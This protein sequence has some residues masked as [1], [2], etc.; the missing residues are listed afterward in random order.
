MKRDSRLF[1]EQLS[2]Y[3][4]SF[5]WCSNK[6]VLDAGS[7]DGYGAHLVSS[8][9]KKITLVDI[10]EKMLSNAKKYHRWLCPAEFIINDF[11]K[12]FPKGKWDTILAFEII[13]HLK[14]SDFF[15]NNIKKHL[16]YMGYFIFSVPHMMKNPAHKVLFDEEKIKKLINKYFMIIEFYIQDL[17]NHRSYF[18]IAQNI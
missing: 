4:Y 16:N 13:E 2:R 8:L 17:T 10:S 14:D 11:E 18:G 7:R 6:S 12:D 9:T 1:R 5:P 3:L 15:V